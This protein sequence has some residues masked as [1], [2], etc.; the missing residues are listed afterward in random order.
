MI[1]Y[2]FGPKFTV[3]MN[4]RCFNHFGKCTPRLSKHTYMNGLQDLLTKNVGSKYI[5]KMQIKELMLPLFMQVYKKYIY[6]NILIILSNF[7]I[8]LFLKVTIKEE[9]SFRTLKMNEIHNSFL[10]DTN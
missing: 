3:R 2:L 4:L 8:G 6:M 1:L 10:S 9:I 7:H 5:I